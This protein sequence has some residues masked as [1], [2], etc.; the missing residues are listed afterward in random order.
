MLT[1]TDLR[2][3]DLR[4]PRIYC[5]W[6]SPSVVN[7]VTFHSTGR[8]KSPRVGQNLSWDWNYCFPLGGCLLEGSALPEHDGWCHMGDDSALESWGLLS[9]FSP[10]SL[11][12]QSLLR[13]HQ[14]TLP[15]PLPEP[16]VSGCKWKFVCWTFIQLFASP[17][18]CLWQRATLPLFTTAILHLLGSDA[19]FWGY[20]LWV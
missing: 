19:Q 9:Q 12:P 17:A 5:L 2:Q 3:P 1:R 8:L 14:P 13:S 7:P 15:L 11:H 16:R 20:K 10:Q 18:V 4:L 6:L